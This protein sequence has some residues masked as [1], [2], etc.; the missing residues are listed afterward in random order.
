M[1][2][3]AGSFANLPAGMTVKTRNWLAASFILAFPFAVFLGFLI[4]ELNRPRPAVQSVS[5]PGQRIEATNVVRPAP[6][7]VTNLVNGP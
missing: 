5:P 4:H 1:I 7:A 6:F 3:S 2:D